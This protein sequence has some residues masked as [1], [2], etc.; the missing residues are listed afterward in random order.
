LQSRRPDQG[1]L[2]RR[3]GR[4]RNEVRGYLRPA[5]DAD[6]DAILLTSSNEWPETTVIEPSSS[7]KDPY[8]YL[9]IVAE[10]KGP[11]STRPSQP[12]CMQAK[13]GSR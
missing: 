13:Q 1:A 12:E 7:W 4:T 2:R 5:T 11:E 8:L 10:W 3:Y 9:K 6:A